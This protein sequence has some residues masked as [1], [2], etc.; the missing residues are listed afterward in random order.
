MTDTI[1][2]K[3]DE[4]LASKVRPVLNSHHGDIKLL[5][6]TQDGFVKVRLIGACSSCP[7]AQQTLTEVVEAALREVYPEMKGVVPVYE[8]SEELI[9]FALK[10][11]RKDRR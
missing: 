9:D 8:A 5:E 11:I 1:Y 2:N 7:G 10:L 3:I 6:I 4:V